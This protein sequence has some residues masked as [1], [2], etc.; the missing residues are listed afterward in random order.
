M[1]LYPPYYHI[2]T[3]LTIAYKTCLYPP[4]YHITTH[5]T[6]AYKTCLYPSVLY[7]HITTHLT[8]GGREDINMFYMLW[9]GEL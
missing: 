7:Y 4:Y 5:L 9:S 2:T 1:F 6:I 8:S 3:H